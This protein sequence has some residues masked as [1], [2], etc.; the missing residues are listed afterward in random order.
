M[1]IIERPDEVN[2]AIEDWLQEKQLSSE[3]EKR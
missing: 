2:R 3:G 1:L